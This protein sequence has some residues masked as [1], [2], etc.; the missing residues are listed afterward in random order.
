MPTPVLS[1]RR[2]SIVLVPVAVAA[3]IALAFAFAARAEVKLHPLFKTEQNPLRA[4]PA[5]EV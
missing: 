2:P 4:D 1:S 3:A 5:V